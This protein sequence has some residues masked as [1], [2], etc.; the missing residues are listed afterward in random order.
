MRRF[1]SL[2]YM[3]IIAVF[4]LV[5][6]DVSAQYQQD[7]LSGQ[8][9]VEGDCCDKHLVSYSITPGTS[10]REMTTDVRTLNTMFQLGSNKTEVGPLATTQSSS[11]SGAGSAGTLTVTLPEALIGEDRDPILFFDE[12]LT[13]EPKI[14]N[15]TDDYVTLAADFPSGT[16]KIEII[17]SWILSEGPYYQTL[18]VVADGKRFS[19]IWGGAPVCNWLFDIEAKKITIHS[20]NATSFRITI[21]N[22]LL[23]PP[24]TAILGGVEYQGVDTETAYGLHNRNFTTISATFEHDASGKMVNDIEIIG[25]TVIPEF[26]SAAAVAFVVATGAMVGSFLLRYK[27]K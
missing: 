17:G 26:G 19:L 15:S 1:G 3:L 25:A 22:E 20:D 23:G 11:E 18:D 21:P 6:A 24:Y 27:V 12:E 2:Q 13:G 14:I 4:S 8:V 16:K 9:E 5:A 10:V 7:P